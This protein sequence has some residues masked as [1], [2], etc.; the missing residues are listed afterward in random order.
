M[1]D[2]FLDVEA[3]IAPVRP[4]PGLLL[5]KVVLDLGRQFTELSFEL[6]CLNDGHRSSA[7]TRPACQS[8]SARVSEFL[9]AFGFS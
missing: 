4:E 5:A 8:R 7:V 9:R 2:Q 3:G 6:G 1:I